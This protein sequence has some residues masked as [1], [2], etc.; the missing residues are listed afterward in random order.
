[1]NVQ[2]EYFTD[3]K[4]GDFVAVSFENNQV[5]GFYCGSGRAN[6]FQFYSFWTIMNYNEGKTKKLYKSYV[7]ANHKWRYA[8]VDP[9]QLNDAYLHKYHI[10]ID[11]L[12]KL[13]IIKP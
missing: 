6:T 2:S 7:N 11:T 1:M 5:L 3:I 10:S 13:N 4:I 9:K 12:T 8:K